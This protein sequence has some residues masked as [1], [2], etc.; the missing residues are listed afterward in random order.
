MPDEILP[1]DP[2]VAKE[3]SVCMEEYPSTTEYFH[4]DKTAEDGLRRDCKSCRKIKTEGDEQSAIALRVEQLDRDTLKALNAL[5]K[6]AVPGAT[7]PHIAEIVESL[8]A[9]FGGRDAYAQHVVAEFLMAKPGGAIRAK[10]VGFIQ[11][12]IVKSTESGAVS[13]PNHLKTTEQLIAERQKT[14]DDFAASVRKIN[15][16]IDIEATPSRGGS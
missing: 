16:V 5:N 10:Y 1:P 2:S 15:H 4:E 7:V 12:G 3:C 8:I 14:I 6:T 9:A 11:Q 13:V